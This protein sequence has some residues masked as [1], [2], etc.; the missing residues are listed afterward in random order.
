MAINR[1]AISKTSITLKK[2]D[3]DAIPMTFDISKVKS[4]VTNPSQMFKWIS[5]DDEKKI[6][7]YVKQNYNTWSDFEKQQVVQW[8]Y[9]AA[10]NK[11]K[12]AD[13]NAWRQQVKLD[14][15]NKANNA[16]DTKTKN[17]YNSQVKK[18]DLADLIKDQYV[19]M[20]YKASDMM[21]LTD[22]WVIAWFLE[23]N[24]EYKDSFNKYFYNNK[25]DATS[26]WKDLWWIEK[27][28]KEEIIW[29]EWDWSSWGK[30]GW[31]AE[32][33]A[34]WTPKRWEWVK[35]FL[36]K[37]LAWTDQNRTSQQN[38]DT[39]AFWNF[40]QD[41]YWTVPA[42][43]TDRDLAQAKKDF[44]ASKEANQKQYTPTYWSA[45]TKMAMWLTDIAFTAWWLK[46]TNLAKN[47]L[48]KLWFAWA[49]QTPWL[50]IVP[51][52]L[53]D[54]LSWVWSNINKLP[55][56]KQIRDSLQT[57]QDKADWD[58]FV[59]WNVLS[60]MRAW[61]RKF[62]EIK[63]ADVQWWKDS[64]DK[65][66]QWNIREW[67]ETLKE[68]AKENRQTKLAKDKLN[69]AQK[70]TQWE[71]ETSKTT[72]EWLEL[73]NKEWKLDK[74]KNIDDLQKN[75]DETVNRLKEEQTQISKKEQKKFWQSDLWLSEDI[76]VLD[77]SGKKTTQK[78]A[79]YP[80]NNL[81]D[82]IIEHYEKTDPAQAT[83]W[84]SYKKSLDG[85]TLPAETILEIRRE[86]NSLNQKVYN[87]KTN[88][89]KDTDKAATWDA[90]MKKVNKVIEW[91][92]IG[93]DIRKRDSQLSSLYTIQEWLK[94]IKKAEANFNKKA[95]KESW[96][97]SSVWKTASR[98]LG[99]L[100]FG[101]TNFL[102]KA[103][104]SMLQ[105]SIWTSWF[106]KTSYN[107][108]EIARKIPEFVKD[109][110]KVLKKIEWEPVSK[111]RL[112]RIVNAF[113]DK[114][115]IEAQQNEEE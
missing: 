17:T 64:F 61:K 18:S 87:N 102:S 101:T 34:W 108:A 112:E 114:W 20:W 16:K 71:I 24:P 37:S 81:L 113:I 7:N 11:Q 19:K 85:W 80:L 3:R 109:Y 32:W 49:S 26:L 66:K 89:L 95:I 105:E 25:K 15:I 92:D 21:N 100:S 82:N 8:L 42:N 69:A 106:M 74:I 5:V 84:K 76:E 57:E 52:A 33:V 70:V 10:L 27:S 65:V 46:G 22:E 43:L 9:N 79:S 35:D 91:L 83:K 23:T 99:K 36:D 4:T 50:Q 86:W 107:A 39:V 38:L 60:L 98:I 94:N 63:D 75:V 77:N 47:N 78:V 110:Q 53:W 111:N 12:Q 72:S 104:V 31:I 28:L 67:V 68:S 40:V 59:A 58:A 45:F 51:E 55:W 6:L 2:A 97:A 48:F 90:T 29:N 115:N 44:E 30:V 96:L 73:L 62:G 1:P 54:T 56:F 41:K 93:E 103:L 88:M 14:L 13:I